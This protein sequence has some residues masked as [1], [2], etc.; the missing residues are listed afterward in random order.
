LTAV[1]VPAGTQAVDSL[2]LSSTIRDVERELQIARLKAVSSNRSM[3]VRFNCPTTGSMRVVEVLGN[4]T[5]DT[6]KARCDGNTYPYPGPSDTDPN[7]PSG[8]GPVRLVHF[9]LTLTGDDIQFSPKGTAMVVRSGTPQA[10]GTVTQV[11]VDGL[12]R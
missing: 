3:R 9:T 5:L 7:T 12:E 4:S 11:E 6:P 10:I 1:A 2:R 8:D